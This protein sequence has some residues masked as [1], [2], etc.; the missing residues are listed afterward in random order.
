MFPTVGGIPVQQIKA[1]TLVEAL[2]PIKARGALETV[3]RL[4]QHVNEIMIYAVNTGLIEANPAS[5]IGMA[6]EKPKKICRH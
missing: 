5:G 2:E 3:R 6:F 1:R 4:V